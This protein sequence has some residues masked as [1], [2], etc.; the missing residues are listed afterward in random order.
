[1][2]K[3]SIIAISAVLFLSIAYPVFAGMQKYKIENYSSI[4]NFYISPDGSNYAFKY[5]DS[6]Q[7][8]VNVSGTIYSGYVKRRQKK[9]KKLLTGGRI[10]DIS[11]LS[12]AGV[13]QW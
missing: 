3:G 8:Y 12:N 5:I 1:M 6:G 4:E 11:L 7:D 13:V 9:L 2:K 10:F